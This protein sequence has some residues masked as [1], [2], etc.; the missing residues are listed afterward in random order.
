MIILY[1]LLCHLYL[2]F[3]IGIL[4]VY[5]V[6]IQTLNALTVT[7]YTVSISDYMPLIKLL[8]SVKYLL[9]KFDYYLIH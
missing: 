7:Y 1:L 5:I 9:I 4:Q 8:K 6:F 2:M 3:G